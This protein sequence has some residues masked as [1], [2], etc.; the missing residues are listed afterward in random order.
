MACLLAALHRRVVLIVCKQLKQAEVQT[1]AILE[2]LLNRRCTLIHATN[3]TT[4]PRLALDL[5]H[6]SNTSILITNPGDLSVAVQTHFV[7]ALVRPEP[8]LVSLKSTSMVLLGSYDQLIRP[9][10][11]LVLFREDIDLSLDTRMLALPSKIGFQ[12][13]LARMREKLPTVT[14]IP[15]IARYVQDIMVFIRTNR[16]VKSGVSPRVSKDLELFA[17]SLCV[18]RDQ[19]YVTPSIISTAAR[20]M[21]PLKI[22]LETPSK[23]PS[24]QWGGDLEVAKIW[25]S[26]WNTELLIESILETV[27]PPL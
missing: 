26:N 8:N 19:E 2:R 15:E 1:T 24:L 5:K 14:M 20:K 25:F 7:D 4:W 6:A 23:E 18:L 16:L 13:Q 12:D 10:R 9:L 27:P 21:L 22:E 11:Q 17:R 3:E